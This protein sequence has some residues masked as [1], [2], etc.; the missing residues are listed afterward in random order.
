MNKASIKKQP[1]LSKTLLRQ[2]GVRVKQAMPGRMRV[3]IN[4]LQ[5]QEITGAWMRERLQHFPGVT[6]VE[7]KPLTG[8][9]IIYFK[10]DQVTI[11]S[12]LMEIVE[13]LLV[14]I[15]YTGILVSTSKRTEGESCD[16]GNSAP[17]ESWRGRKTRVIWLSGFMAYA[18]ARMWIFG[19]P[20]LQTPLSLL[21]VAAMIGTAPL[22]RDSTT[23]LL[24]KKK[25]TVKPFL[26]AGS[27]AT[28]AM[29][30]AFS[31]LQII[32]IYNVAELTEEYVTRRSRQAIR[33]IL[34][35]APAN[36]YVMIDGMEVET[37]VTEIR[38]G[39][40]V[41]V[42]T[43][44]K[45]PVDGTVLDGEALVDEASINGRSEAVHHKPGDTVFAGTIVSQGILFIETEKTG[46]DTYLAHIMQMVED[47]MT[48]RA[49]VEQKADQL[50]KRLLKIGLAATALTLLIT[51][52]PMRALT[53]MLVMS[54][55]CATVLAAS[56][57]VTAAVA[58]AAKDSVLIKGGLYLETIGRTDSYC[59]DK[60]GT[61]TM[62]QPEIIAVI[63]RIPSLS[64]E[65][66]IS[67]AATAESHNQHPMAKAILAEAKARGLVPEPHAVCEFKAGRGV[68]CT[69]GGE[70]TILVGNR[71]FMEEQQ[72]DIRWFTKKAKAQRT[73]GNTV[74]YI[75]R[76]GKA[77]GML[78]V[79][80]PVRPEAV[81]VLNCLRG[82]GVKSMYLVTGDTEEV[83]RSLMDVFP[84]DDCRAGLLPEEKADWV[85]KLKRE[86][87]NTV[88]MV[89][90][91]VNDALALAHADIGIAMGAAGA[92]VAMEAAD[93]ALADSNLEGLM[94]V[95]NLSHQTMRVIDQNH[96]LAVS[97]DLI[98]AALAMAGILSPV[99][100]GM[101]HI[102][103]TGG[104][105]F[106]SGR[107]LSWEPPV[108]P[109]DHCRG[110]IRACKCGNGRCKNK[111]KTC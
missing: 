27:L 14:P 48:N 60:T 18:A 28:I 78:G 41:A 87:N 38:P 98:G 39:D 66:I 7:I 106:N 22:V 17:E 75:A 6:N 79:A 9:V 33:D 99:M 103:H 65:K 1:H 74:V 49:P 110:C 12:L 93:I 82:D 36:A 51:L 91:G 13:Q 8:S 67:M 90:D 58:N 24:E 86:K 88:V 62:D 101:I 70:A 25:I 81:R 94:K 53:V 105:L 23:E 5:Y 37:Q 44:E 72:V 68:L 3:R 102:L 89:G 57:A 4:Q 42:H 63:P 59:F 107:L 76:N 20:L 43:G 54:C 26:A 83:A 32:W 84:F 96:Y 97:T 85:D 95:R 45:L 71:Q 77:Q 10:A 11:R 46:E 64:E 73:I 61:L 19:L 100:A 55:P 34:E 69:V 15:R 35:V 2:T 109:M 30:Q 52:D 29:G 21:G 111:N 80:N 47:S 56:S 31:A 108:E 104:I 92:E 50:A 40:V 16:C